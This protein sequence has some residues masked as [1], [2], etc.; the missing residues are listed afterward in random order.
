MGNFSDKVVVITGAAGGLGQGIVAYF[1]NQGA[2]LALVDYSDELLNKAF[3]QSDQE[4]EILVSCDL[5]SREST[6]AAFEHIL[7]RFG[8]ID[9]LANIAGGFTMGEAVHETSDKTWDF[10]LNLN[11]RSIIN[12]AAVA[13]PA[14]LQQGAGKII[15]VA[16]ASSVK[17]A[18]LQG[19]YLASKCAVARLSETMADELRAKHINVNYIMP[20]IIDTPV[21]R[22]SMPNADF[23]KWVKPEELANVVGFLASDASSA[24]HGAGIPVVGLS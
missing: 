22:D 5:T 13:V 17:G 14:M 2:K 23:S 3:P 19:A 4:N 16:S 12:T 6:Q 9:V 10:L 15:N 1:R 7:G 24:V 18:A 20:S 8:R 21:N 11:T